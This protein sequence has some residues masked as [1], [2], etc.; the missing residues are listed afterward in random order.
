MQLWIFHPHCANWQSLCQ[1]IVCAGR[2]ELQP[3]DICV[4]V[5]VWHQEVDVLNL[6][7][8]T[9]IIQ[10]NDFSLHYLEMT[11]VNEDKFHG[12]GQGKS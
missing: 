12:V 10:Y 5:P 8:P 4:S 11:V 9:T 6:L 1:K 3:K 7:K 2:V